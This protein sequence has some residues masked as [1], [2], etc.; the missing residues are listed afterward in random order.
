MA[1][2]LWKDR[3]PQW[4]NATVGGGST[5]H[6]FYVIFQNED[7]RKYGCTRESQSYLKINFDLFVFFS[8]TLKF[9]NSAPMT[10]CFLSFVTCSNAVF[11]LLFW[12]HFFYFVNDF[13]TSVNFWLLWCSSAKNAYKSF[14]HRW[15]ANWVNF[16]NPRTRSKF[17]RISSTSRTDC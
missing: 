7:S 1:I 4:A 12:V 16:L 10:P 15:R 11:L 6:D 5:F 9:Q 3:L 8:L 2:V 17:A 14:G 13:E